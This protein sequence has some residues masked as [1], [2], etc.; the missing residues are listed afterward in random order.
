[1][2]KFK[3]ATT[4]DLKRRN[5]AAYHQARICWDN[6]ANPMKGRILGGP[7]DTDAVE[8]LVRLGFDPRKVQTAW[9]KGQS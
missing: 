1:M 8:I 3:Y 2:P 6:L 4:A 7:T 5:P 9:E